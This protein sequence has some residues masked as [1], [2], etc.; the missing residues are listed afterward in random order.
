MFIH[1]CP[2]VQQGEGCRSS[3][4][5]GSRGE[6]VVIDLKIFPGEDHAPAAQKEGLP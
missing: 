6:M 3:H 2:N 5:D 4:E 1:Y